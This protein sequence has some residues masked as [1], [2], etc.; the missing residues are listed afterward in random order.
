MA[1]RGKPLGNK[2]QREQAKAR[3]RRDKAARKEAR[4][5]GPPGEGEP[6]EGEPGEGQAGGTGERPVFEEGGALPPITID[7][8]EDPPKDPPA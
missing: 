1:K 5:T 2:R 7:T 8:P 3:K 4:L 6:G